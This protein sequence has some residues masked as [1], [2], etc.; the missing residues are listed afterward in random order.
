MVSVASARGEHCRPNLPLTPV[1]SPGNLGA[2]KQSGLPRLHISLGVASVSETSL[3]SAS[4]QK[5]IY[6]GEGG[7]GNTPSFCPCLSCHSCLW[8]A[9]SSLAACMI[10]CGEQTWC[11]LLPRRALALKTET[12]DPTRAFEG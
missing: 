8:R 9:L 4:S 2:E 3:V 5:I 6:A 7:C 11:S 10:L 12:S 1:L